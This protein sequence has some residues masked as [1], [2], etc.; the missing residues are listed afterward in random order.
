MHQNNFCKLFEDLMA[1]RSADD[2]RRI[3]QVLG[4]KQSQ[5]LDEPI[6]SSGLAWRAFGNNLSNISTIGLATNPGRSLTERLT[7]AMDA[8]LEERVNPGM[9]LPSSSRAAA[10]AWYGRPVSG[11]DEGL[12]NWL[13]DESEYDRRIAV[14]LLESGSESA[15][16]VDVLDHGIGLGA[17]EFSSTILSLQSGNKINKRYLIG[18]FG[19]GG[20]STL[21]FSDYVLIVSRPKSANETVAFTVVR[22]V[23]LDE[24]YKEDAYGYLSICGDTPLVPQCEIGVDPIDLYPSSGLKKKYE[25]SHGTLIRHFSYRLSNLTNRLSASPGNLYHYL[26]SSS[27]DPLFPF[28]IVDLRSDVCRDERVSGSRNRLMK[29]VKKSEDDRESGGKI[30]MRHYRPMEYVVPVGTDEACVGIEYWVILATRKAKRKGK[31]ETI[32]RSQSNELYVQPNHPIIATMN[33]QNQ[34]EL[35]AKLIRDL[36]LGMLSR[37]MVIHIDATNADSRVRRE[38]FSTSRESLKEGPVLE[39]LLGVVR[40]MLEEDECLAEIEKELTE[41]L[42]EQSSRSTSEEVRKQVSKLLREAGYRVK[43]DGTTTKPGEE[44]D[45]ESIQRKKQR[46]PVVFDPLHTLPYPEV[47]RFEIVHPKPQMDV[48][49]N[50]TE[51]VLIE[52]NAD[53]RFYAEDRIALRIEPDILELAGV[54]PLRGGRLRWRLRPNINATEGAIGTIVATITKLDGTQI[55]DST[56]FEI[57]PE[58]I[59]PTKESKGDVPPFEIIPINPT[60]EPEKWGMIW[61]HL[62]DEED[63]QKLQSV[64]Y[65]PIKQPNGIIVYYSTIFL[66]YAQQVKLLGEK[67]PALLELF[68]TNF[69]VWIAYHA[70]LQ[71]ESPTEPTHTDEMS[72]ELIE[73]MLDEDRVRVATMQ[74]KQAIRTAELMH[75]CMKMQATAD[76]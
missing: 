68:R 52:T 1:A 45:D 64:A 61:T 41:R 10:L 2:V 13:F 62:S 25:L 22:V 50:D 39:G 74:A 11:P 17:H 37:H 33:G 73:R 51:V 53:S 67:R 28:R 9:Q 3:L 5:Q 27:F 69:E 15:P 47:T 21:A 56:N 49:I 8:L 12:F 46:R 38:L 31:E 72:E 63:D 71:T 18:A 66:P 16:T 20:A 59:Q 57:Q 48:S 75:E 58:R 32:L 6:G 60:D 36:G 23:K 24:S 30:E 42:T 19:Q 65:K 44:G 35:T 7:N 70:I 34:G 14:V 4:D 40:K 76:A 26:H 54:S 55:L 43:D 29:L